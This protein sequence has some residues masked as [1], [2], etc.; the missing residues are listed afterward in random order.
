MPF[1]AE[2]SKVLSHLARGV[3]A[4]AVERQPDDLTLRDATVLTRYETKIWLLRVVTTE[5]ATLE[6][7]RSITWKHVDGPL[8]GSVETFRVEAAPGGGTAVRYEGEVAARNRWL[9]GPLEWLLVA[10]LT[11]MVSMKALKEA[12]LAMRTEEKGDPD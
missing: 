8:A 6:P 5:E 9:R 3:L 7:G 2:G 11:R 10:P 1:R 4:H 12:S